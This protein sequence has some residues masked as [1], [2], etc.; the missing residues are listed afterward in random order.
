MIIDPPPLGQ[1]MC[2]SEG[3]VLP[4]TELNTLGQLHIESLLDP[5]LG[6]AFALAFAVAASIG[7]LVGYLLG[8]GWR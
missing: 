6:A 5:I 4:C 8:G 3:S 1:Y 2:I 7:V